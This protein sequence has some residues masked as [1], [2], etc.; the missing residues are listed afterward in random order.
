[1]G[2]IEITASGKLKYEGIISLQSNSVLTLPPHV[3]ML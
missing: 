3:P 1:M 2:E